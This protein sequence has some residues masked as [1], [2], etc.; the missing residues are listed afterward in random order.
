MIA[1]SD[2]LINDVMLLVIWNSKV[3]RPFSSPARAA[4]LKRALSQEGVRDS[5]QCFPIGHRNCNY[6]MNFLKSPSKFDNFPASG[7]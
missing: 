6:L 2:W 7:N 3:K 5:S 1:V 4:V